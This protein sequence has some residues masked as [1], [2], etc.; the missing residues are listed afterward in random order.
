MFIEGNTYENVVCEM[1]FI[2]F[3]PQCVK[4][5]LAMSEIISFA[6]TVVNIKL[7]NIRQGKKEFKKKCH[8]LKWHI[9][10]HQICGRH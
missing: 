9:S 1:L 3:R 4:S 10:T 5:R 8:R 6:A 7:E 2:S